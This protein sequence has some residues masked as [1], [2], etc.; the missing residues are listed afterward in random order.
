[1]LNIPHRRFHAL[2]GEWV[3]VSRHRAKRPSLGQAE[4]LAAENLRAYGPT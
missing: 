4:E 3:L 2:T 1:M